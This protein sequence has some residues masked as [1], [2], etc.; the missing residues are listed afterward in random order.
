MA[1]FFRRHLTDDFRRFY[2][3]M[4]WNALAHGKRADEKSDGRLALPPYLTK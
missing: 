2:A 3:F 4:A 1:R